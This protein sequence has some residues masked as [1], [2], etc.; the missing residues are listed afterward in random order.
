MGYGLGRSPFFI[1]SA[2]G[3]KHKKLVVFSFIIIY[4]YYIADHK[5]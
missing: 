1:V 2:K 4:N 3:K 5:T